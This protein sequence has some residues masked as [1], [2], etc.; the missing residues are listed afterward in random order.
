MFIKYLKLYS[1]F[2]ELPDKIKQIRLYYLN[3]YEILFIKFNI[4]L[5]YLNYATRRAYHIH[6]NV[7]KMLR[8]N[9]FMYVNF[10]KKLNSLSYI[11]RK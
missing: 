6:L 3:N 4:K 2:L 9:S 1:I 10:V 11:S 7:I 5:Y 8:K